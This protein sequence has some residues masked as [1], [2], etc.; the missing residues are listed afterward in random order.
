MCGA[1]VMSTSP[2]LKLLVPPNAVGASSC[3]FR[4]EEW[5]RAMT[6]IYRVILKLHAIRLEPIQREFGDK[7]VRAEF[8]RH[9]I[10]NEKYAKIFYT[11]W[12]DYVVQLERGVTGRSLTK[13]EREL[14]TD[15]QKKTLGE[16][17]SYVVQQRQVD[18]DF[19]L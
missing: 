19:V 1:Q 6:T 14:L 8:R 18:G 10:A 15:E 4:S 11:S 5:R 7:F 12:Y 3:A 9:A 2:V 16:I 17:R 13:A